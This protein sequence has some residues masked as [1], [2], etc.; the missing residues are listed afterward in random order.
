MPAARPT[1]TITD[2]CSVISEAGFGIR[3]PGIGL[4]LEWFVT[5]EGIP[6]TEPAVI[7]AAIDTGGPLPGK[8]RITFEPG[9]QLEISA[10]PST[11][12]PSALELAERDASE[13]DDAGRSPL[14]DRARDQVDHVRSGRQHH[15]EG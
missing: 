9:G 8:S 2:A 12:G 7:H 14:R 5:T 3:P 15:A 1:L 13:R 4:E 10:P 11:C 6:V